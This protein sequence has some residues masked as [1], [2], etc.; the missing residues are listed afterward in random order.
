[1]W[2]TVLSLNRSFWFIIFKNQKNKGDG[3]APGE[4]AFCGSAP[5]EDSDDL[6]MVYVKQA[7]CF[8]SKH[9]WFHTNLDKLFTC[10]PGSPFIMDVWKCVIPLL[11]DHIQAPDIVVQVRAFRRGSDIILVYS[12]SH[13][14][15]AGAEVERAH[16]V[17]GPIVF[18]RK[19]VQGFTWAGQRLRG[20]IFLEHAPE[21]FL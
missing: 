12:I 2:I 6:Q 3:L 7:T 5:D 14:S 16:T 10:M 19:L 15:E 17:C 13:R 20:L 18:Q 1:M 11:V 9:F 8:A 4:D 21:A